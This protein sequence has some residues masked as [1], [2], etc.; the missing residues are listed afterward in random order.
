MISRSDQISQDTSFTLDKITASLFDQSMEER[1]ETLRR[2]LKQDHMFII[3]FLE[4]INPLFDGR[5]NNA[6]AMDCVREELIKPAAADKDVIR[7]AAIIGEQAVVDLLLCHGG[8]VGEAVKGA[9]IGW[10]DEFA[11]D[12]VKKNIN[13]HCQNPDFRHAV[14]RELAS[15]VSYRAEARFEYRKLVKKLVNEDNACRKEAIK[16]ALKGGDLSFLVEL[17]DNHD[18]DLDW[19]IRQLVAKADGFVVEDPKNLE[20]VRKIFNLKGECILKDIFYAI[21][22]YDDDVVDA[23]LKKS[24][25]DYTGFA[26]LAANLYG[27]ADFATK[28]IGTGNNNKHVPVLDNPVSSVQLAGS[29]SRAFS[30]WKKMEK[31][32]INNNE[33]HCHNKKR[34]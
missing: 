9:L 21:L 25:Y 6:K 2:V 16:G 14:V 17:T 4:Y 19:T 22:S 27:R 7:K 12:L 15:L 5:T 26:V 8:D 29:Y 23:L 18:E 20:L 32:D 10:H 3:R 30:F 1:R 13:D 31:K 34:K 24:C 11:Y 33:S 28:L